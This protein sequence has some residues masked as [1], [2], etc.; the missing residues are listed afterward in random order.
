MR[1]CAVSLPELRIELVREVDSESARLPLAVVVAPA[2]MTE[3]KLLGNTRL[4]VVSRE[5]R[6]LGILPG[7]TIAQARARAGDLAVRV[8]RPDAVRDVLARL[9][10]VGLS[11]GATVSFGMD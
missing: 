7:H 3:Q 4:S 6:A 2:P 8:V 5:A 10:E 9:A 11:F 1:V